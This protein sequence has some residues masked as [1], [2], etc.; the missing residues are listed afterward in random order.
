MTHTH[1][2][3]IGGTGLSAIARVLLERGQ[4]VSGSDKELSPLAENLKKAGVTVFTGHAAEHIRGADVVVR[5]SAVPDD[6]IEV[7]AA[8]QAGIPVLKRVDYL[9]QLLDGYTTIGIAGS[10]GKTSTT[11]M[12]AWTLTAL[13]QR[14]GF[15]VGG[16]VQNLNTNAHAGRGPLFVIEADEYDYMFW[17]LAPKIAVVTNIE[18]DHPDCFP[19]PE[20]F[21]QA[22]QGFADRIVPG[23]TLAAC[24]DDPGAAKLLAYAKEKGTQTWSYSLSDPGADYSARNLVSQPESG[25]RFEAWRGEEKLAEVSLRVPGVHNVSNALAA[26]IVADLLGLDLQEAGEALEDFLGSGRRF[27]ILGQANGVVVVDDYGHHPTEIKATLA[28]AK[29]RYPGK[30][31]WAVWQPHTYSR[32][33][34]LLAEFGAA[35][36]DADQVIVTQVYAA[37]EETPEG[38]SHQQIVDAIEQGQAR[39]IQGLDETV[40]IL[41][42]EVQAGDVVIVF[43]AGDATEVSAKLFA[44]LQQ[45]EGQRA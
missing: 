14:P 25:Y 44:G 2:I 21:Y 22:F 9:G 40:D 18:H 4:T 8:Q 19:T 5:S 20:N 45:K 11:S 1:F 27:D 37:R 32:T 10:H 30:R 15:I 24:L 29:D 42:S 38:F 23:G 13:N 33:L 6:N 16:V 26:L 7:A 31:I 36:G 41:L 35:F 34:Q 39:Y 12:A 43:S 28:A 3:G 17:G